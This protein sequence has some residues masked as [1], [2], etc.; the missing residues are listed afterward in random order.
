M[1][2]ADIIRNIVQNF[3]W[4]TIDDIES[5]VNYIAS[6]KKEEFNMDFELSIEYDEGGK[7]LSERTDQGKLQVEIG[8]LPLYS[9]KSDKELGFS[10]DYIEERKEFIELILLTFHEL[11]HVKQSIDIIDRPIVNEETLRMTTERIINY[12]L[13]GLINIYNYETSVQEVDAM[14]TS[15]IEAST[16]FKDMDFAISPDEIF[17][18]MKEKE[19]KFL[20]Y[21]LGDFGNSY[22]G[23]LNNFK[24]I[25]KTPSEIKGVNEI[26]QALPTEKKEII[27]NECLELLS[28][29]NSE[30]DIKKKLGILTEISLIISPEVKTMYPLCQYLNCSLG[31]DLSSKMRN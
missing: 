13:P 15:L 3:E 11:R 22:V 1:Q 12:S 27:N 2:E 23:A 28:K 16:F 10:T 24:K 6:K 31:N 8:I 21:N 4:S 26:I 18:V 25:I 5:V 17:E 7:I 9:I 30:V 20:N 29:Y 19:L 14:V